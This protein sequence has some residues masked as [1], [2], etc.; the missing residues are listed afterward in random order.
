MIHTLQPDAVIHNNRHGEPLPG[1]DV[2]G[3]EQDLPGQNTVGFNTTKIFDIP[4]EVCM[5]INDN[6]G[7]HQQDE[8]HK[9]TQRLIRTL[10]RSASV[11][12]N[13]LL[14]IGPTAEG[15]ILPVHAERLRAVGQWLAVNGE[16]IYGT[17]AGLIPPTQ[18]G[19]FV[20]TS[21]GKVQYIHALDYISDCL[22]LREV[23]TTLT[24]ATLL[25]DGS[26]VKLTHKAETSI[27]TLSAAQRDA[28]DTVIRL[29]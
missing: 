10:V 23:P 13:Y 11:G 27:L 9:S 2:Q 12:A 18:D 8:N 19:S 14:N 22:T 1:E 5:T 26:P 6:W 3:F 24:K 25:S 16:S 4:I 21:Q 7:L 15:E 17:R 28:N 20:S 29:E